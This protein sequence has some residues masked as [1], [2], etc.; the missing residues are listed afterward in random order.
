[1]NVEELLRHL[2]RYKGE[3]FRVALVG[4]YK[5]GRYVEPPPLKS[6]AALLYL[7]LALSALPLLVTKDVWI[8]WAM[9]T[10]LIVGAYLATYA[11]L[12][13]KCFTPDLVKVVRTNHGDVEHLRRNKLQ[14][15]ENPSS[16]PGD[17]EVYYTAPRVCV[18]KDKRPN[19]FTL[20]GPKG[21]VVYFTT[22]LFAR[23]SPEEI[24]A[25]LEHEVGH[26][27][28]RHTYKLLAFLNAE[29][30]LRLTLVHLIYLKYAVYLLALHLIGVTLLFTAMLQAFEF[31]ADNYAAAKSREKLASAL[32][33]LD[34]N[35]IIETLQ[36]PIA[37]RLTLLA[38]TH[39]LTIDRLRKIHVLPI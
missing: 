17:Y 2:R 37:T 34:W 28:Y 14:V 29:Y 10:A 4:T 30:A 18:A 20:D 27:K 16:L 7:P 15:L 33:K 3:S 1:M 11:Y 9:G 24:Q 38:R 36:S 21:P 22:G 6:D 8:Q 32:V 31:E 35:G 13:A 23:L 25:V 12:R 26:V 39:P 5:G 19:A